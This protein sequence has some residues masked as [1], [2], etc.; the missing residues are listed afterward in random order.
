VSTLGQLKT[1]VDSWLSRDDVAVSGSDFPQILLI[2]ESNISRD[3]RLVL[4]EATATLNFTGRSANLPS[5]FMGAR[6][7]FI[8]DD[9]RQMTYM[10][11][12]V[13]RESSAWNDGRAGAYYTFEGNNASPL[14]SPVQQMTIAGPASATAPLNV[15]INYWARFPALSGDSSTNW[16]LANHFDIYLYAALTSA[17]QLIQEWELY[18]KY[19]AIY[20]ASVARQNLHESRKRYGG[21]SKV[22]SGS[23]R[24]IV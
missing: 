6:T 17:C 20:D 23:G 3:V 12:Q 14:A 13:L 21:M 22:A 19:S 11:P 2:A 16:L 24:T 7:P 1:S 8:D 5:D 9:T 10:S 18:D 15:Q 4:Q